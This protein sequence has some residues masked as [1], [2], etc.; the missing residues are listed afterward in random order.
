M[1]KWKEYDPLTGVVETNVADGETGQLTVH[2]SQ[3]VEGLLERNKVLRNSGATD[4]GITKG[5]WHYA[6][7]PLTVQYELLKKGIN[8]HDRLDRA[9]LLDELNSNYQYLKTTNKT[10]SL[11]RKRGTTPETTTPR[12]PA[13]IIR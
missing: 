9:K 6:S 13:L 7:I 2:K 4:I 3:D 1:S 5:L 8:V 11:R 10:H 12:G